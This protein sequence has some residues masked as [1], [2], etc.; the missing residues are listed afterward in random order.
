MFRSNNFFTESARQ[1]MNENSTVREI[2]NVHRYE[3]NPV[4]HY[5]NRFFTQNEKEEILDLYHEKKMDV[6]EIACKLNSLPNHITWSLL[7]WRYS[8][9][10]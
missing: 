6:F 4:N 3:N 7:R 5:R 8:K 2:S 1:K 9:A 10:N